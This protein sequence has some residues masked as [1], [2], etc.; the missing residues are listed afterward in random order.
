MST[1]FSKRS[2]ELQ[3]ISLAI[4]HGQ[5]QASDADWY[6]ILTNSGSELTAMQPDMARMQIKASEVDPNKRLYGKAMV[7]KVRPEGQSH[8]LR[9]VFQSSNKTIEFR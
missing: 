5:Q 3:Q 4:E 6:Q 9:L 1:S 2:A 7:T 8:G